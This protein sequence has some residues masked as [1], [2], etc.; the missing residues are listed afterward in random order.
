MK[1]KH[2]LHVPCDASL[3][4]DNKDENRIAIEVETGKPD[5]QRNI[6]KFR[7]FYL[8]KVFLLQEEI[9]SSNPVSCIFKN[10]NPQKALHLL[11]TDPALRSQHIGLKKSKIG[12]WGI[13]PETF[14]IIP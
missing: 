12:G 14:L 6:R 4:W 7:K 1:F 10:T 3:S 8:R 2:V 13:Q 9:V 5:V 11:P